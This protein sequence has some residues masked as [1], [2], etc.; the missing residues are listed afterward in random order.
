M[1]LQ[2]RRVTLPAITPLVL[3]KRVIKVFSEDGTNRALEVANDI[4]ALN[5]CQLL[6]QR[7]HYVDDQNWTVFEHLSSLYLE[8]IIEDHE[9]I[10]EVQSKW[11]MDEDCRFSVR[12]YFAK[13]EFFKN[14]E[15]YF[16]DL[17]LSYSN[18]INGTTKLVDTVKMFLSSN[19]YPEVH[20]YLYVGEKGKKS[21]KK[22]YFILRRSGLYFSTKGTSKDPRHLQFF[23]D[24]T[25]S[26]I[27]MLLF[28][29]KRYGAPT[30]YGLC[31]KPNKTGG[32]KEMKLLCAE[33][34][35]SKMCWVTAIRLFKHGKQ[36]YQNFLRPQQKSDVNGQHFPAMRSISENSL[37]AMDFSG[38]KS[39][40]IENPTE[41]LSVALQEG[42]LWRRKS[43]GRINVHGVTTGSPNSAM[44]LA[45]HLSQP[46]FHHKV[47]RDEA[48][49]L[50][51]QQ[52]L[53]NGLFLV[54]D[55]QS[56]PKSFVLSMCYGQKIKHFQISPMKEEDKGDLYYTLDEG[57][58]KFTDLTQLVEFHQLNKG[59]LPCTLKHY[60]TRFTI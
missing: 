2:A 60:C 14:P 23:C 51:C 56:T 18:E 42:L 22:H 3:Q 1:N 54:R 45:V 36:I 30:D 25:Q 52:G 37:V 48:Q 34:E 46:W 13:Y 5:L 8:R 53:V 6:I 20:S 12:K 17:M 9:M 15:T 27:Y 59:I 28:A 29:K 10:I 19:T 47:S 38:H 32:A 50:I 24:F 33:S 35:E 16:P 44:G 26:H 4:T 21:W 57:Q 43:C 55:S 31:L 7:N 49:K 41:V 58:T 40:V 11:D 39:R